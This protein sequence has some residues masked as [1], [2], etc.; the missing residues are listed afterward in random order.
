MA[1]RPRLGRTVRVAAVWLLIWL[2]P[3]AGLV[4]LAGRDSVYTQESLFFSKTAMVTFGGAYSVLSYVA[5][6]C[7]DSY[8][9]LDRRRNARRTRH[10]GDDARA[11]DSGCA[12][13]RIHGRL[14]QPG[15]AVAAGG[16]RGRLG[17]HDVGHLRRPAFCGFSSAHRIS[18]TFAAAEH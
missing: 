13:C 6:Q 18:N 16:R 4:M 5:E 2:T 10:G 3:V 7:V 1:D 11:A 14:S 12:I 9:W 8:H 17:H 15:S